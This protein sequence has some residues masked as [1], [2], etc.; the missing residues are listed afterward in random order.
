MRGRCDGR[1]SQEPRS[2]IKKKDKER[3]L[4]KDPQRRLGALGGIVGRQG[5][6]G[7]SCPYRCGTGLNKVGWTNFGEK[8]R[9]GESLQC[10]REGEKRTWGKKS[11]AMRLLGRKKTAAGGGLQKDQIRGIVERGEERKCR[12]SHIGRREQKVSKNSMKKESKRKEKQVGAVKESCCPRLTRKSE[13]S[14]K[15]SERRD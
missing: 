5:E 8:G 2:S 6:R 14:G 15:T 9:E 4:R 7:S 13:R 12:Q 10:A 1:V 11:Q 3:G